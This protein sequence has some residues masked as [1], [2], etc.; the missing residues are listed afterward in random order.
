MKKFIVF[1]FFLFLLYPCNVFALEK[2]NEVF[3]S[4]FLDSFKKND[5]NKIS[6]MIY[7][8]FQRKYPIPPINNKKEFLNRFDEVFDK[9]TT[10]LIKNSSL[11]D[12]DEIS[13]RGIALNNGDVWINFEGKVY[14]IPN[15]SDVEKSKRKNLIQK[16]KDSIHKSLRTFQEPI[17]QFK[18]KNYF[19]RIDK[20]DENKYRYSSWDKSKSQLSKP[21]LILYGN[22]NY[23][24]TG[25][26]HEY[27]FKNGDYIYT[28]N[29]IIIGENNDLGYLN[30]SFKDKEL[31]SEKFLELKK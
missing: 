14:A 30:V 13:W 28:C 25:G 7:Y 18:T 4:K 9:K 1:L 5:R 3:V 16:E 10:V 19:V 6:N 27:I 23:M 2:G 12:W 29:I 17:M 21:K 20:I 11:K 26:N 8:P 31:L 24:G 15:L 22:I